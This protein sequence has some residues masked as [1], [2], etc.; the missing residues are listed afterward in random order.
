MSKFI[1][2]YVN[3]ALSYNGYLEKKTNGHLE[4]F[5]KNAGSNNYT[6]F[7]RDYG[8][9]TGVGEK[10]WQAQPWCAMFVSVCL[11]EALNGDVNKAKD[12]FCGDLYANVNNAYRAFKNKGRIFSQPEVGDLIF[13]YNDAKTKYAHIG[14][15]YKV[16]AENVYTIEGNTNSDAGV[17]ANGGAVAKKVY[18][19]KFKYI[20]GYGRLL[21]PKKEIEFSEVNINGMVSVKTQL[22]V[23]SGPGSDYPVI[24]TVK[25]GAAAHITKLTKDNWGYAKN[26]DGWIVMDYIEKLNFPVAYFEVKGTKY[27]VIAKNGVNVRTG[28]GT[29]YSLIKT[30][31]KGT[32]II[33]KNIIDD[34]GYCPEHKGWIC[35]K[36]LE[37]LK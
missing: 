7:N 21:E 29:T 32:K 24:K 26:L 19:R 6:K 4:D 9:Y 3:K 17:V 18:N 5:T 37:E 22:N 36:Y 23:R 20:G 8:K 28:A 33:I 15:V 27:Q 31:P 35:L 25:T 34:W 1:T 14:L 11:V 10:Y 16:S 13:F 2:D 30:L 12:M